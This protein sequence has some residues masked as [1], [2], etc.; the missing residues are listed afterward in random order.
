MLKSCSIGNEKDQLKVL[1]TELSNYFYQFLYSKFSLEF[2]Y[3][4]NSFLKKCELRAL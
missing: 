3:V 4:S 1:N 2:K